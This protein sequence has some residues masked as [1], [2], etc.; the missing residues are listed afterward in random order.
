MQRHVVHCD[1]DREAGVLHGIAGE[2]FHARHG[3]AL[4]PPH[5]GR[6]EFTHM[7]GIFA[8]G[9]LRSTPG[10][11]S[12]D[13]DADPAEEVGSDRPE[14]LPDGLADA[15]F[16]IEVPGGPPGHRDGKARRRT[17][18]HSPW[19]VGKGEPGDAEPFDAGRGKR[20]LVVAAI[21]QVVQ[22]G[23][24]GK[25]PIEA[26][27]LLLGCHFGDDGR[28]RNRFGDPVADGGHGLVIG[29]GVVSHQKTVPPAGS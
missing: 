27:Q 21:L 3:M 25:V 16:E 8:V 18:H 17:D 29:T 20:A 7:E 22:T 10:G 9:F 11:V 5:Q 13:I 15:L 26:P 6:P 2:V 23:P 28:R 4:D 24:E 12:Q 1:V 19:P 14:L